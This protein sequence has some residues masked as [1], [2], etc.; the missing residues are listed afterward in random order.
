MADWTVKRRVAVGRVSLAAASS[1][2]LVA[3]AFGVSTAKAASADGSG[4]EK[5]N[6]A[7]VAGDANAAAEKT[8]KAKKAEKS[9]ANE[10]AAVELF[11]DLKFERGFEIVNGPK[12]LGVLRLPFDGENDKVGGTGKTG[13]IDET[14]NLSKLGKTGETSEAVA[15]AP[16]W[17]LAQHWS[18]FDLSRPETQ[19]A[20]ATEARAATPGLAVAR[21]KTPDGSV[22]LRLEVAADAE[23]DAPR[24]ADQNWLHLLLQR[25]FPPSERV[26]FGDVESLVFTCD[27]QVLRSE[28]LMTEAE[29]N[30]DLH[31]TQASVYFA[32]S[33]DD[34]ESPDFRDYIWFGVSFFDD[35]WEIQTDYVAVDGDPKSIGTGKLIYR[36]GEQ[37]T[38][39][40]ILG[41]VNPFSK[42]PVR[43]E[44]DL[45]KYLGGA[46]QAAKERGFLTETRVEQMKLAHFNFGWETP[47]TYRA[48]LEIKNPRLVATLKKTVGDAK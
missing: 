5:A 23:Y 45:A 22:A 42:K 12:T 46:L 11:G 38:I 16:T 21:T 43:I 1:A 36:L 25:D 27:A 15:A 20:T 44:I 10:T 13:K 47:G 41:G 18:K 33:N 2:A 35:R 3:A 34:P 7:A 40:D 32:I 28:R 29:F 26:S 48:A 19:T 4:N 31:A 17:K 24:R 37:R 9:A 14:E 30:P 39:D 8:E 6:A